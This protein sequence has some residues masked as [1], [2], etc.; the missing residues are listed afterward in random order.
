MTEKE[1]WSNLEGIDTDGIT[2]LSEIK[3]LLEGELNDDEVT[4]L[5]CN[6]V[7]DGSPSSAGY[8][9]IPYLIKGSDK[10]T[11]KTQ[12]EMVAAACLIIG[13]SSSDEAPKI[14]SMLIENFTE[15]V[16]KTALQRLFLLA[17]EVDLTPDDLI[18]VSANAFMLTG[19]RD[20]YEYLIDKL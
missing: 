8:G 7:R 2:A 10:L 17:S 4:E 3:R 15:N 18:S 1:M 5:M 14:D 12:F 19:R 9:A 16:K 20:I 11:P 6:L 13:L